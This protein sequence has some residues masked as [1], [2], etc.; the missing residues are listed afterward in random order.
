MRFGLLAAALPALVALELWQLFT[1]VRRRLALNRSIHELRRPLQALV[2][3]A[4]AAR[5]DR[6]ALRACLEQA[7][8]ALGQLDSTINGGGA[9]SPAVSIPLAEVT[10]ALDCR[11]RA[12]GVAVHPPE[13][14]GAVLAN[15][16][17][18][19]G[20]V[21]NLVANAL[22]HG[23]GR[24]DVRATSDGSGARIEVRDQGPPGSP[25]PRN[26]DRRRGHG[27]A[28]AN[29]A[30]AGFGGA[31]LGPSRTDDGGTLAALTLPTAGREPGG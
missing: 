20:A 8:G 21:D 2:L 5:P 14:E 10:S 11:W 31:L 1:G 28:I 17:R 25:P 3:L 12:F 29:E 15:P 6:A 13:G 9:S 27:L 16:K 24:V 18:L 26:R 19:A 22:T 4:E 23:S 7:G 30:A